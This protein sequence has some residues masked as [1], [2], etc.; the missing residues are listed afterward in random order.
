MMGQVAFLDGRVRAT[1]QDQNKA[2]AA[3]L[4]DLHEQ[5]G[6]LSALRAGTFTGAKIGRAAAPYWKSL[7]KLGDEAP[8]LAA[9]TPKPILVLSGGYDWNV[10]PN[11]TEDWANTFA[12]VPATSAAH[13]T[14]VLPCVTHALNCIQ[15]PDPALIGMD[16]I[17]CNVDARVIETVVQFLKAH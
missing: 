6:A 4:K 10:P 5:V 16:D 14:K 13:A 8:A 3:A 12:A 15:Q 9:A 17:D 1:G 11:E 2:I 7:L